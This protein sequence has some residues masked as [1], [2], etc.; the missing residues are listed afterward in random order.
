MLIASPP[1]PPPPPAPVIAEV[2]YVEDGNSGDELGRSSAVRGPFIVGGRWLADPNGQTNAG[3]ARIWRIAADGS[4]V[5]EG[6]V[7]APDA[8]PHDEMGVSVGV[9]P[10]IGDEC[11]FGDPDDPATW[12]RLIAGAWRADLPGKSNAGAAYV[13]RRDPAT[14]SWEFEAKLVASDSATNSEFGRGVA[15]VGDRAIVGAWKH[16]GSRGAL[17]AFRREGTTWIE[18]AKLLA[19]DGTFGD[20]LGVAV[21][22]DGDRAIGGAWAKNNGANTNQ[23]A[24]YVFRRT[25]ASWTQEA[26]LVAADG[27]AHDEFGRGVAIDD[28]TVVV[29][30]WPFWT[31]G[32]GAAYAF[33]R[34]G[35]TWTQQAKLTH[36]DAEPNDYFGFSVGVSGDVA[37]VGA[38]ADNVGANNNQ[39]SAHVF[40]RDDGN[41][42]TGT[43]SHWT[44]LVREDGQPSAYFGFSVAIDRAVAVV[45]SRLENVG[46]NTNQGS[47][48]VVCVDVESCGNCIDTASPA[49]LN[50]DGT[51]DGADLGILLASWGSRGPGDLNGDGVVD[52]A[53]LGLL[54]AAWSE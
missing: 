10:A 32:P 30:T 36:P 5:A 33:T 42:P 53:D 23:G 14:A 7:V 39:G 35:T 44:E 40:R 41:G 11:A 25:G 38:W 17:Y 28:A 47:V 31:D 13:F 1:P 34:S 22:F 27:A 3:A 6:E 12:P 26:K 43:W 8:A 9:T 52:G 24:A 21:A 16:Q 2:L 20:G 37:I 45:G 51:V 46:A 50:G 15:I 29:G 54:L 48:T 49:D 19:G 18:E 4:I